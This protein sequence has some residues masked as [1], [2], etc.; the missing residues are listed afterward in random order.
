MILSFATK[1]FVSKIL[2]GEKIHTIRNDFGNRFRTGRTIHAW[3]KNPR[4]K[5]SNPYHFSTF[6]C[7]STQTILIKYEEYNVKDIVHIPRIFVDGLELSFDKIKLLAVNDGFE[8]LG[9]FLQW[10][11]S[12]YSG[13]IIHFTNLKY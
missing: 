1:D 10:F 5:S 7:I 4:N 13:K 2:Y 3:Y 6:E 8:N 11:N 9:D 12:N